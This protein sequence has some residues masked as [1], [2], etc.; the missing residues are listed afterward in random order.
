EI[1]RGRRVELINSILRYSVL[2]L[3]CVAF[4]VLAYMFRGSVT[5][6][7]IPLLGFVVFLVLWP[8]FEKFR[9]LERISAEFRPG[10]IN[11]SAAATGTDDY[12]RLQ[13]DLAKKK[14]EL[15]TVKIQQE[16]DYY[17]SNSFLPETAADERS[18]EEKKETLQLGRSSTDPT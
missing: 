11:L 14:V 6:A 17:K 1:K 5:L 13:A 16:L 9:L 7:S 3:G 4:F 10:G 18:K 8:V 12:M 15:E 2:V